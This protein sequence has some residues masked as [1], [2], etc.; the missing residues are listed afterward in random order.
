MFYLSVCF[1]LDLKKIYFNGKSK[2]DRDHHNKNTM[3]ELRRE[4]SVVPL[5]CL[6]VLKTNLAAESAR[7]SEYKRCLRGNVSEV[8]C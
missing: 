7:L 3:S 4:R 1:S 5:F 6:F 2:A 8:L